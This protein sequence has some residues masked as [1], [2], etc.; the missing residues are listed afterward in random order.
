VASYVDMACAG[1]S[2]RAMEETIAMV[3]TRGFKIL[4]TRRFKRLSFLLLLVA[5]TRPKVL[6]LDC[7]KY[8]RSIAVTFIVIY[9]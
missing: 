6:K 9:F 4:K 7:L 1:R 2:K 5:C 8:A 3:G